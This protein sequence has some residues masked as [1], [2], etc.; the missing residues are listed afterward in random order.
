MEP[1]VKF[2]GGRTE[3]AARR[4][5]PEQEQAAVNAAAGSLGTCGPFFLFPGIPQQNNEKRLRLQTAVIPKWS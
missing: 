3:N 2:A 4:A 1:S 5:E